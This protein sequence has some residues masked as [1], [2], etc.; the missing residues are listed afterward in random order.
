LD[1]DV[2]ITADLVARLPEWSDIKIDDY[3]IISSRAGSMRYQVVDG[4]HETHLPSGMVEYWFSL[5]LE[6]Q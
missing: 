6:G 4:G 3:I 5:R 2:S 1:S